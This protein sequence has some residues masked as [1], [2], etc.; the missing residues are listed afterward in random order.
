MNISLHWLR[1]YLQG[2]APSREQVEHALIHAG[3][4]IESAETIT[5]GD[6][7]P[8]VRF[9]VEI[10]S[11]RGDGLSHLGLAREVAAQSRGQLRFVPPKVDALPLDD[12]PTSKWLGLSNTAPGDC[13]RFTARVIRGVQVGPSPSWLREALE[14]V[15]QRSINNVVDATNFLN[16]E[17]GQPCHAFDLARLEGPELVVRF[18]RD[19]EAL[20]TLDSKVRT[21]RSDELVVADAKRAQGLAGVMGGLESEVTPGT[22]DLVLE[23][24]TWSPT[25]V[26]RAARRHQL[27]TDASYRYERLVDA[28]AVDAAASR[29]AQLITL[30]AGGRVCTGPLAAGPDVPDATTIPLRPRRIVRILGYAIEP[31]RVVGVLGALG[32]EVAPLGRAGEDLLCTVPADRPDL[33]REIDL[34]EEIARTHGLGE[35]PTHEKVSIAVRGPQDSE[36]AR[37]EVASTLAGLGFHEAV[38][39]SFVSRELADAFLPAGLSRVEVDDARRKEDPA[40]RPSL[41]PS[42]LACRRLNQSAQAPTGVRLFELAAVFA[43]RASPASSPES[44]ERSNL[45]LLVDVPV[46]GKNPTPADRQAGVR[47]MR[48]TIDAVVRVCRGAD[49]PLRVEPAPP[50]APAFDPNAY[51]RLLLGDQPLGYFGVIAPAMQQG[52]SLAVPVVAAELDASALLPHFPPRVR[53]TPLPTFPSIERD[54]SL[55]LSEQTT[56][57]H[58]ERA[59]AEQPVPRLEDWTFVGTYRGPQAGPGRKSLTLRLRFRDPQRTLRHEEIDEPVAELVARL[60]TSLHAELRA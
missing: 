29:A 3:F 11:N 49:A 19:Q 47:A 32:I 50:H 22:R 6:G 20:T 2:G 15:G 51:A 25:T 5:R 53:V 39:F 52:F 23:V 34:I 1:Q 57:A 33:T 46:T 40:L 55:I 4:P 30:A 21:L 10:T 43:Q 56:W 59:L 58:V 12:T 7:T 31:D 54:L 26:R 9:D 27:R 42:L 48:G 13:P 44:I 45:G 41:I 38:T 14:S 16:F 37:R 60:K 36:I 8:D 28:R 17:W 18:A 35:I 24:A